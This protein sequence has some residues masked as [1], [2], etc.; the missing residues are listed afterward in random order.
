[1]WL[2]TS[3]IQT[4]DL[5]V[6]EPNLSDIYNPS[7]STLDPDFSVHHL[8][9]SSS[10]VYLRVF[11]SDLLFNEANAERE[12]R[13][14]LII[15]YK[16]LYVDEEKNRL[17]LKDSASMEKVL[18]YENVR[19]SY[20]TAV[21]LKA[22]LGSRYILQLNMKDGLRGSENRKFM[23]IDKTSRFNKQN[24]R[25]LSTITGYPVFTE[26]F[27]SADLFRLE[28][29]MLGYDSIY[30]DYYSLDRTLPRPIFSAAPEIQMR[31]FPDS[32]YILPFNDTMTFHLPE[33]G[34]YLFR[35]TEDVQE[36]C[37]L[38]NFGDNFPKIETPNELLGPLVYLA[39]TAEFRDLRLEPNRKLAIDNF[40]LNMANDMD[41]ARE[42]IRVFYSRVLYSNTY[43]TSYKEGWKTDRGMIYIIFGPP[44]MLEKFPDEEVWRYRTR[45]SN[46]PLEFKFERKDNH[47]SYDDYQ[48]DRSS[49]S[50]AIWSE[51]VQSWKRGRI[52]AAD[53]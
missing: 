31:T 15:Q 9:D 32:T 8:N 36:G 39:T 22:Y 26:V 43:F 5:Q 6:R 50:T 30:V 23:V 3:C 44:D 45:K 52:Y 18:V 51:A 42:L 48:L 24:F 14:K 4:Q 34:I 17:V 7:R 27:S 29:N 11:P 25:V 13:A 10:I 33:A 21:P 49:S 47:L 35:M 38:Y 41:D 40:W 2:V 1:M 53:Y 37:A 46:S 28:F 20:F 16:L 19:N 12:M